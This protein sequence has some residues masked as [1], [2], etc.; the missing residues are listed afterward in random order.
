MVDMKG[1]FRELEVVVSRGRPV[2]QVRS[3][4]VRSGQVS[5]TSAVTA[6]SPHG[7]GATQLVLPESVKV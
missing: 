4:Q 5:P 1:L 2:R 6:V 3:G 7:Y